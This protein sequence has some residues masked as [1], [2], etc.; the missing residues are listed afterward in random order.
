MRPRSYWQQ[1]QSH[2]EHEGWNTGSHRLS[3]TYYVSGTALSALPVLTHLVL[4]RSLREEESTFAISALGN[5]DTRKTADYCVACKPQNWDLN[6]SSLA[7]SLHG[8][9]RQPLCA[10]YSELGSLVAQ[11]GHLI[12]SGVYLSHLPSPHLPSAWCLKRKKRKK[13]EE[14]WNMHSTKILLITK[15]IS[16]TVLDTDN[17]LV[18][19]KRYGPCCQGKWPL[20]LVGNGH[21]SNN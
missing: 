5:R 1:L 11:P 12:F 4:T 10:C 9:T 17:K 18:S 16:D 15:Y 19:R 14:F 3:S 21:Y 2:R 20:F 6:P 13:K 7:Q 8:L